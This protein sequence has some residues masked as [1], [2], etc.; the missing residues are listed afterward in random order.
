MF[1]NVPKTSYRK[2]A[3]PIWNVY[4]SGGRKFAIGEKR[5]YTE[6]FEVELDV[7]PYPYGGLLLEPY[8][9]NFSDPALKPIVSENNSK[10]ILIQ[11]YANYDDNSTAPMYVEVVPATE[12]SGLEGIGRIR[13]YPAECDENKIHFKVNFVSLV[14]KD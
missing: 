5:L 2:G 10:F 6:P 12:K 7:Y 14:L 1:V 8:T 3:S 11:V 9:L 13:I 4:D